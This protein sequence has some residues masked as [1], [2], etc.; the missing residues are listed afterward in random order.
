MPVTS[1]NC[2]N[3]GAP[4]RLAENQRRALC[5]Y[6]GSTLQTERATAPATTLTLPVDVYDQMKQLIVDGHR[7][8]AI[9][10]YRQQAG[11]TEAEALETLTGI[12]RDLTRRTLVQQPISN[13][14]LAV[15]FALDTVFGILIV[16]GLATENWWLM[17]LGVVLLVIE[18]LAFGAAMYAR[19]VQNFGRSARAVVLRFTRLGEISLQGQAQPVLV[20][21]LWLE[22]QP[23][24]QPTFQA[25]R[26]IVAKP[27]SYAKLK[28]GISLE[29]RHNNAGYVIPTTPMKILP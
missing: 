19:I 20:V 6:C 11:V 23:P 5:L 16:W 15:M 3:C 8:E 29:V 4:L 13:F 25:E 7:A 24:G 14:G 22:V 18:T 2:P 26:N 27:E 17:G 10:L 21:R 12:I 1:L 28:P 9:A